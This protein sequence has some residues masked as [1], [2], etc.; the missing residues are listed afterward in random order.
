M[1]VRTRKSTTLFHLT[2]DSASLIKQLAG[3]EESSS[4]LFKSFDSFPFVEPL[5]PFEF[6]CSCFLVRSMFIISA[7]AAYCSCSCWSKAF[8]WAL[9]SLET[10]A[11]RRV[12]NL[13][14]QASNFSFEKAPNLCTGL[15]FFFAT[16]VLPSS[17]NK[18]VVKKHM[19]NRV[20]SLFRTLRNVP[21]FHPRE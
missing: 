2:I 15:L 14:A 8:H 4:V 13:A 19:R 17:L 11:T 1:Q 21:C 18:T 7:C 3:F 5:A 6:W 12:P 10:M 16:R 9:N 20:A